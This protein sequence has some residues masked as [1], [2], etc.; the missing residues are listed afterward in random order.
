MGKNQRFDIRQMTS[1]ALHLHQRIRAKIDF[2][3]IINQ[4]A[5][6]GPQVCAAAFARFFASVTNTK[7]R[8][9]T[10]GGGSSQDTNLHDINSLHGVKSTL[11]DSDVNLRERATEEF[12]LDYDEVR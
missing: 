2:Q 10:F 3:I 6:T 1:G 9:P 12:P 11:A 4:C 8:W 7:R 5:R